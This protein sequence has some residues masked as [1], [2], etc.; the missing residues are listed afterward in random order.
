M[1]VEIQNTSEKVLEAVNFQVLDSRYNQVRVD[2]NE[3]GTVQRN[4]DSINWI[5]EKFE[6]QQ[7]GKFEFTTNGNLNSILPF[8]LAAKIPGSITQLKVGTEIDVLH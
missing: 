6:P 5:I 4:A 3:L 1:T 7:S 2:E 8:T